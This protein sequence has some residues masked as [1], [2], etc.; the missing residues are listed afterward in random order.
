MLAGPP[1]AAYRLG[2]FV[3]RHRLGVGIGAGVAVL[4]VG[5]L[6]TLAVQAGRIARE[7]DRANRAASELEQVAKFQAAQ[8]SGIDPERMGVDLER[9]LM[10]ELRSAF[11]RT[12]DDPARIESR[13]ADLRRE[14]APVNFTSV[15]LGTLEETIF[16]RALTTIDAEFEGQPLVRA[17]LLQSLADTLVDV[18]L[19]DEAEA[20]QTEAL[21]IRRA[22]LGDLHPDTLTS[23]AGMARVRAR[24]DSLLDDAVRLYREAVEGRTRVL[25][26]EHRDTLEAMVCLAKVVG[27]SR[28]HVE[29][30]ALAREALARCIRV[31]GEDDPL[32]LK[33][34]LDL[35]LL[36][37]WELEGFE[38]AE[39]EMRLTHRLARS[40]LGADHP[41]TQ[42][43]NA[44]LGGLL[45]SMGRLDGAEPLLREALEVQRKQYGEDH[46]KTIGTAQNLAV[47]VDDQGRLDEAIALSERVLE[48]SE[49]RLGPD[50]RVSLAAGNNLAFL[51]YK[52]GRL[53]EAEAGLRYVLEHYG[54]SGDDPYFVRG[55]LAMVHVAR[56]RAAEAEPLARDALAHAIE[57]KGPESWDVAHVR[58]QLGLALTALGRFDEAER[59]LLAAH[60]VLLTTLGD[61]HERTRRVE[62]YLADLY[63]ARDAAEPGA[64]HAASAE[65]WRKRLLLARGVE[66]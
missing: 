42:E 36:L 7:R 16:D 35:A 65:R 25:G 37:S 23:I 59:E 6:V 50:N 11:Q 28:A 64:G 58:G 62:E 32:S 17:R 9:R 26:P 46:W 40:A 24:H 54:P 60:G 13:L 44:V 30:L 10:D 55:N 48:I 38:E 21:R 14:M 39:T 27:D 57:I 31:L 41:I 19:T 8:L 66:R 4:L 20:P 1:G 3:R 47:V 29:G 12:L 43:A 63:T 34:R 51:R 5:S 33:A 2:K 56:G 45:W 22:L 53:A 52:Q 49:R 15:A 18:S 61:H